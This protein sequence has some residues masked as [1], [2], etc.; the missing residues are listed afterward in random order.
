LSAL[1]YYVLDTNTIIDLHLGNLLQ[2]IFRLPCRFSVTDSLIDEFHNPPFRV[3]EELGLCFESLSSEEMAE[4][5]VLM[6]R[7]P[8]PSFYDISVMVLAKA[9]NTVLITGDEALRHAAT[10]NGVDCRGTCWLIDYLASE[11]LIT[12]AEA[13]AAYN[14]IRKKPRYP[15]R[16]EC[17]SLLARWK[18]RQKML[19]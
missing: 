3:L 13:I 16:D 5:P 14:V 2:R 18:Q 7:Y 11:F 12:Y 17:R 9:R 8:K 15:P 4:I 10:D 19:E 6:E 1:Q